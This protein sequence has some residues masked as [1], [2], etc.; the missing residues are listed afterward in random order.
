MFPKDIFPLKVKE[1][2]I[3]MNSNICK[4]IID[5]EIKSSGFFCYIPF[6]ED[7]RISFPVLITNNTIINESVFSKEKNSQI[8]LELDQGKVQ[9]KLI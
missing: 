8:V 9:K 4:I 5:L 1:I 2:I 6:S 7:Y 3:Q